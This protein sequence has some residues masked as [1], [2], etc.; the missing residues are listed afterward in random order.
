MSTIK[1]WG[2]KHKQ[3]LI[4]IA[5]AYLFSLAL[6]MV[7]VYHF[8]EAESF[9]YNNQLMINTNDG[10]Y[11][12]KGAQDVLNGVDTQE[13]RSASN[14]ALSLT[15]AALAKVLPVSFETLILYMPA[16]FSS[17]LVIPLVLIGKSLGRLEVGFIAALIASIA[18]SYYN[19]TM[20][21]YYD[22]DMLNIVLPTV[23]LWSLIAAV[24]SKHNIYLL[25]IALDA[26]VYRWWYPQSYALEFA[27]IM[28]IV[29]Y[30]GYLRY[31]KEDISYFLKLIALMLVA[32]LMTYGLVRLVAIIGLYFAFSKYDVKRYL[33]YILTV[34]VA[35][36]WYLG[37]LDPILSQLNKYV[38]RETVS[39]EKDSGLGLQF[40]TVMQTVKEASAIP[41]E[42]FANRISGHVIT[43]VLGL[44]GYAWLCY[45][46][47]AMLLAL[48]MLGLGFLAYGIPGII[49]AGGLRFTIYAVPVLA[50]GFAFFIVQITSYFQHEAL[51]YIAYVGLVA[52]A[53]MPNIAH[54]NEYKVP[55]VFN[56]SEVSVLQKLGEIATP[57]DYTIAW[58]DYGYPIEYYS[59][60]RTL[61]DGG[62]HSGS[63]NFPVSYA[64]TNPQH[65]GA[66]M[67]R[68]G[69]E[70][71]IKSLQARRYNKTAAEDERK[72]IFS[73]IEQMTTDYGFRDTNDFLS[74]IETLETPKPTRDIYF[75]L[76][77][78]MSSIY[79][80]A[81]FFS[82][83]DLMSGEKYARP[84]FYETN[85]FEDTGA[86]VDLGNNIVLDK[87]KAQILQ[88]GQSR[89]VKRFI[90]TLYDANGKLN[91]NTQTLN[92]NGLTVVF[93]QSYKKVLVIDESVF[94]SLYFQL[95]FL[96]NY[97]AAIFEQV[98]S[99][100]LA[101]VYKLK[102]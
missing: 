65:K 13:M 64:L 69:V 47:K 76:P 27:F 28:L 83:L 94:E 93:L 9:K 68:F 50:L 33:P 85:F 91:V 3:V 4:F 25:I 41:F 63:V 52:L 44:I 17:F 31:K 57:K 23:L 7:W 90:T 60:T 102:I 89:N 39:L 58:W 82:N 46:H 42:L 22:T 71:E 54:I 32:T 26:F 59:N 11:F 96:E 21:G 35:V 15:T 62:R 73:T 8:S 86:Q 78:R 20:V 70:Y 100:P 19:R 1:E 66:K 49:D 88:N 72:Q 6:R 53:L 2:I 61:I 51:K 81:T 80:V 16:F 34:I 101:K 43:F 5:I 74:L 56:Q 55:T 30:A 92:S 77:L 79:T 67:A 48:P 97:D 98:V 36:F 40:F 45:R 24:R 87:A 12:A 84:T 37:G 29:A 95:F 38:F 14:T 10:Y 18:W 75:Y 99:S